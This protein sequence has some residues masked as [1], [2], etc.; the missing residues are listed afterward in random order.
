MMKIKIEVVPEY[1]IAYIRQIGSYGADNIQTM[2]KLKTW[3]KDNH[4]LDH[5]S[6][7]L[8]IA[9][10]NPDITRA[11]DCRYDTCLVISKNYCINEDYVHR[12]KIMEGICNF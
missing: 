10:D 7:I 1:E 8:G 9:L 6:I 3:A 2:E 12:G 11:E 5:E 4:L